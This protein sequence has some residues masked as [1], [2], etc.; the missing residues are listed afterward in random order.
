M[1]QWVDVV[2]C[3]HSD[4]GCGCF[5]QMTAGLHGELCIAEAAK[6]EGWVY[7]DGQAMKPCWKA[8]HKDCGTVAHC[9]ML[10]LHCYQCHEAVHCKHCCNGTLLVP[11]GKANADLP[12]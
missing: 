6:R 12:A 8:H 9:S 10:E 7:K 4:P 3:H 11:A 2:P 5:I 1:N